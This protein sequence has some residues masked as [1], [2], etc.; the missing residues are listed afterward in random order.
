MA[1]SAQTHAAKKREA[2]QTREEKYAAASAALNNGAYKTMV[3]AATAF[4]V[5]YH[6]LRRRHK[7]LTLPC[8]KAHENAQLLRDAQEQ[9]VCDWLQAEAKAT[10]V[11]RGPGKHWVEYFLSRHPQIKLSRPTG[12]DPK[13]AQNFNYT[14][15]QHHF[16][17]LSKFLESNTL[18]ENGWTSNFIGAE[19]FEKP[20][21]VGIFGPL[22]RAWQQR[23]N[24]YLEEHG[25][26]ILK[27][28]VIREYMK[29][30][31]SAFKAE[32][33][34]H[35]W[36]KTGMCPLNPGIFTEEDYAPS[37]ATSTSAH[38]PAT[39]PQQL[40]SIS[41]SSEESSDD[42]S[43]KPSETESTEGEGDNEAGED[44]P[45]CDQ[46]HA[47]SHTG[48]PTVPSN[49]TSPAPTPSIM[50]QD[51]S[52]S[53]SPFERLTQSSSDARS[54]RRTSSR[55]SSRSNT[56]SYG[57]LSSCA[58]SRHSSR[59][60][61]ISFSS[62][63][64]NLVKELEYARG[65][66]QDAEAELHELKSENEQLRNLNSAAETHCHFAHK[67]LED[68]QRKLNEKSTTRSKGAK[69]ISSMSRVLTT[70]EGRAELRQLEV[71]EEEQRQQEVIKQKKKADEEL[72]R[73]RRR[74]QQEQS[75]VFS[76]TLH[77]KKKE[78]L[79]DIA[80]C[81]RLDDQ[82][83]VAALV[84]RIKTFFDANPAIRQSE[85]YARLRLDRSRLRGTKR[86]AHEQLDDNL[87]PASNDAS[88][89]SQF[90]G[91]S[92]HKR[93]R[94][95]STALSSASIPTLSPPSLISTGIQSNSSESQP[96]AADPQPNRNYT[97]NPGNP[98][99]HYTQNHF[100]SHHYRS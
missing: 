32:T 53:S 35:A 88:Q 81:L 15:V 25:Q 21:D 41:L 74:V 38:V 28:D 89:V 63:R 42:A 79:S 2:E 31:E 9:V 97:M 77:N 95:D 1:C 12:L 17:L 90:P 43:Y 67:M 71:Q 60:S 24:Q 23:C 78:E 68:S 7:H 14:T 59:L 99:L 11:K 75:A 52:R 39:F 83:T 47:L 44:Q 64:E 80:A 19:W 92:Q 16:A 66:L 33:I 56:P 4:G 61:N 36:K 40:S 20:L 50:P 10:G 5:N 93:A 13:R 91:S 30:R 100:L 70:E 49:N 46:S 58:V 96:A 26:G 57:N 82:G 62:S 37:Y 65:R 73:Q 85:R 34:I 48:L 51:I 3:G 69:K 86:T 45:H 29:A 55:L 27:K 94:T 18:S 87:N 22:Q 98:Y 72:E 54:H 6:T 84:E 76:G 8:S